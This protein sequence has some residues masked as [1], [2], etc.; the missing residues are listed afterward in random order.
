MII[1][2]NVEDYSIELFDLAK[3]FGIEKNQDEIDHIE[4][5]EGDLIH[6]KFTLKRDGREKEFVLLSTY[7]N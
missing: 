1:N 5:E 7:K 4:A 3:L 6:N 2:T